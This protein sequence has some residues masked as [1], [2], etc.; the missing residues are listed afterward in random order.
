MMGWVDSSIHD[1]KK[2]EPRNETLAFLVTRVWDKCY[3]YHLGLSAVVFV[4]VDQT[5][6]R[7]P[8]EVDST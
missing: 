6:L 2:K 1:A 8:Y 7:I 4:S 5:C 3:I